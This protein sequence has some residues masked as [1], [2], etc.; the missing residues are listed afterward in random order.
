MV[1]IAWQV[2]IT[3]PSWHILPRGGGV[4]V[5]ALIVLL[6]GVP[7][8]VVILEVESLLVRHVNSIPLHS[9]T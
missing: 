3:S 8:F 9:Q 7:G 1:F 4:S 6:P 2:G 5:Y